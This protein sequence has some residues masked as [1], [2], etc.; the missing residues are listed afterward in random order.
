MCCIFYTYLS[1]KTNISN[2]L[3]KEEEKFA[4]T[5]IHVKLYIKNYKFIHDI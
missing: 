1:G 4:L 3:H 5:H 2:K